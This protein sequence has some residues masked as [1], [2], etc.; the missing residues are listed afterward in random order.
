MVRVIALLALSFV[1]ANT[2]FTKDLLESNINEANVN[3]INAAKSQQKIDALYEESRENLQLFR[4]TSAEIAQLTMYNK[5]LLQI[6]DDQ[7]RQITSK[8]QQLLDIEKT[9]DGIMPLMERMLANLDKFISLDIPFLMDERQSR[10]ANL[11]ALL[12]S[13]EATTSEKFRRVLEAYQIELEY[14]R[15]IEAFRESVDGVMVDHLRLGRNALYYISLTGDAPHVWSVD[16][17]A[18]IALDEHYASDISQGIQI[19]RKQLTPKLLRL[20]V[21]TI[22]GE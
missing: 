8:Q 7:Y 2:A 5:Q 13:S 6:T 15:T 20:K 9:Q 18:W 16:S 22:K 19:A 4:L 17:K 11:R 3:S 12:V 10:V 1:L 14:G 21:P